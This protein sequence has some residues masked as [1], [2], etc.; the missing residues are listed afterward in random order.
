[1]CQVTTAHS[2]LD[3]TRALH[4]LAVSCAAPILVHCPCDEASAAPRVV[5]TAPTEVPSC[6]RAVEPLARSEDLGYAFDHTDDHPAPEVDAFIACRPV[7]VHYAD[8]TADHFGARHRAVRSWAASGA[9]VHIVRPQLAQLWLDHHRHRFPLQAFG[10]E[11]ALKNMEYNV[12]NDQPP[13]PTGSVSGAQKDDDGEAEVYAEDVT[14]ARRNGQLVFW[15]SLS[16]SNGS[17]F[18]GDRDS[19]SSM[20]ATKPS[21]ARDKL[22]KFRES[23]RRKSEETGD[24]EV[25]LFMC[26]QVCVYLSLCWRVYVFL[27]VYAHHTCWCM[28]SR[29]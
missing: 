17:T 8:L 1:M 22:R 11:L 7:V 28:A 3:T 26:V 16:L 21:S 18:S 4:S 13:A 19:T 14:M 12:L 24:V 15:G 6:P 25:R 29:C 9:V 27:C 10:A 20:A 23:F 2:L 5:C